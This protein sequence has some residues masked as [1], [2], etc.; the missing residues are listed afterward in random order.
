M[1]DDPFL[2]FQILRKILAGYLFWFLLGGVPPV[3]AAEYPAVLGLEK[4]VELSTPVSG[5]VSELSVRV[6]ERVNKGQLLLKLDYRPFL[7]EIDQARSEVRRLAVALEEARREKDRAEE[8]YARTL[9]SDHELQLARIEWTTADAKL[10]SAKTDLARARLNLEYS[11]VRAPFNGRV[12]ERHAE[13]GQ[14]LVQRLRST[15]LIV[16]AASEWI[17]ARILMTPEQ[18]STVTTGQEAIVKVEEHVYTGTVRS[19]GFTP[20]SGKTVSVFYPVDVVFH[21]DSAV[22]FRAGQPAT[23][24][25]SGDSL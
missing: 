15:P 21:T 23:V 6:G 13:V 24:V 17:R 10:E 3:W 11:M 5:I 20:V 16:L 9:L 1:G 14:T 2:K 4:K 12:L 7:L 18:I 25:F 22:I 8:L 19:I